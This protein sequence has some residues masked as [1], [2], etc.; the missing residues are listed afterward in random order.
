MENE[1]IGRVTAR[2][3]YLSWD[4]YFMEVAVLTSKRSK[5]PKT[6]VGACI[7]NTKNHIVGTGYNGFPRGAHNPDCVLFGADNPFPWDSGHH[8]D[9]DTKYPYV[10]HAEPN[11]ILNCYTSDLTGCT[12]YVTQVP[13]NECAK[14]IIQSGIKK[15]YYLEGNVSDEKSALAS[16]KL[17]MSCGVSC[18][19][20]GD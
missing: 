14:L 6:Q 2:T 3:D 19:K 16:T 9:P 8:S 12:M 20:L 18:K 17:F 4:E 1:T 10:V 7:A 13:C 11:A 15:V 5:D